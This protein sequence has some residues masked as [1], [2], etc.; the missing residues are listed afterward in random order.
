MQ[1]I[2]FF[3]KIIVFSLCFFLNLEVFAA[4]PAERRAALNQGVIKIVAGSRGGTYTQLTSEMMSVLPKTFVGKN[5][6]VV[7]IIGNGSWQNIQDILYLNGVDAALVQSD[8][9]KAYARDEEP[10]VQSRIKYIAKLHN[11]EVHILARNN[12]KSI[13]ELEGKKVGF[14]AVGSGTAMTTKI[15]LDTLNIKTIPIHKNLD[16][17]IKALK[18]KEIDAFFYVSGKPVPAIR[19][20]INALDPIHFLP[21]NTPLLDKIY[22]KT[23]INSED[24]PNIVSGDPVPSIAAE[25]VLA[26]Y[27]FDHRKAK[28]KKRYEN[29]TDFA[30][31]L[32]SGIDELKNGEYHKKWRTIDPCATV[33]GWNRLDIVNS[34]CQSSPSRMSKMQKE[35]IEIYIGRGLSPSSANMLV[36]KMNNDKVEKELLHYIKYQ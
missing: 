6:R 21:L 3:S 35:L 23:K 9:L 11:E 12:I 18:N 34:I 26:V 27:D 7:P 30:R 15:I 28:H 33:V 2:H 22:A 24:Y 8:V 31:A 16:D 29:V 17:S 36:G 14:G 25:A 5:L 10:G 1:S 32:I 19:T 13:K 4:S 20:E